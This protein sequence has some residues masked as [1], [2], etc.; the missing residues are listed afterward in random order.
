MKHILS[1][2]RI[3]SS[4]LELLVIIKKIGFLLFFKE[5]ILKFQPDEILSKGET[6]ISRVHLLEILTNK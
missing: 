1:K 2:F 5:K 4:D 6:T 3:I